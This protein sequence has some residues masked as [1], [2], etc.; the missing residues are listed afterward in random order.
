MQH[1]VLYPPGRIYLIRLPKTTKTPK[2]SNLLLSKNKGSFH[3]EFLGV[4]TNL[5]EISEYFLPVD[6][7]SQN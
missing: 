3:L 6:T 4:S 2:N 5:T 7:S 1:S